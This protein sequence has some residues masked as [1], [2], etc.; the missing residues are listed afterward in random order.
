MGPGCAGILNRFNGRFP[1]FFLGRASGH[2]GSRA[3][4]LRIPVR[5]AGEEAV[6][7]T[8]LVDNEEAEDETD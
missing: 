5:M 8:H 7:E 6:D 3:G 2:F 1:H 4:L